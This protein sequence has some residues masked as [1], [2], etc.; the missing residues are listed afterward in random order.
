MT[1]FLY[2]PSTPSGKS[3]NSI[4]APL[5]LLT[6]SNT[7]SCVSGDINFLASGILSGIFL[8]PASALGILLSAVIPTA[9]WAWKEGGILP[10][11]SWS[12]AFFMSDLLTACPTPDTLVSKAVVLEAF[13][14][15]WEGCLTFPV[16]PAFFVSKSAL[17]LFFVCGI[18]SLAVISSPFRA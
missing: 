2:T 15:Y 14:T 6:A 1:P 10:S 3:A 7:L 8:T 5:L 13:W 12:A 18:L 4:F 9:S 11:T 16:W 17:T